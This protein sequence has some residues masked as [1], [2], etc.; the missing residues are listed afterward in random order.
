MLKI[1]LVESFGSEADNRCFVSPSLLRSKGAGVTPQS[2][3]HSGD[4]G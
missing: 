4:M 2:R 1:G 3:N